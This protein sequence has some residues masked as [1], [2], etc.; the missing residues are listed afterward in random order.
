MQILN[1][2]HADLGALA[3]ASK[4][5]Y[6]HAAPFPNIHF[7]NFFDDAFLNRVLEE[8]PDLSATRD[9]KRYNNHNEVK[10]AGI[11]EQTFGFPTKL[12]VHYLN[13]EPFLL[14]L[15]ELTGIRETLLPDP[16]LE[17]GG[18][19]EIKSGG[20]LKIHADFNKSRRSGL[21]RRIN[22]LV[23]LNKDWQD[24]WGGHF[25]LWDKDM[26]GCVAS[27]PPYFNTMAIFSTTD[28]SFHGHP[29]ALACP[30]DRSRKSIALYYYSNGRPAS[31]ISDREEHGTLFRGRA[32]VADDARTST[33]KNIARDWLPPVITRAL[34]K[35]R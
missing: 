12:L 18:H 15:Q 27:I 26:K 28:F 22:V 34:R 13:S 17:G 5:A 30:P 32:G 2:A 4:G 23:Y 10:L 19:H 24:S 25:E 11:G 9:A 3:T 21:D 16:Y 33:L 20:L 6:Q 31:E 35:K 7:S 1:T 29:D 8:F 14:F